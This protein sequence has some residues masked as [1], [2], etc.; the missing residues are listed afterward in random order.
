MHQLAK[1]TTMQYNTRFRNS[2]G[3]AMFLAIVSSPFSPHQRLHKN[4]KSPNP[5]SLAE[6]Q[7]DLTSYHFHR[8]YIEDEEEDALA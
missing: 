5:L 6:T 2:N 8:S 4:W 7:E 3:P 1:P